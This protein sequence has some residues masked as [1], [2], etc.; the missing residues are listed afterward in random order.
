LTSLNLSSNGLTGE[1]GDEMS[2]NTEISAVIR[3]R[4]T[5]DIHFAG[6]AALANA[7]PDMGALSKLDVGENNIN[8]KGKSALEKAA[9]V[10]VFWSR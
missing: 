3:Y 2:G 10:G 8:A 5:P 1:Y 9:G 4:T 6:I 7:I